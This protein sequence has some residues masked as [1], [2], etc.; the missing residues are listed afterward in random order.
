[1]S[2][3]IAL[4]G[5]F[6][7]ECWVNVPVLNAQQEYLIETYGIGGP[8]GYVLRLNW[9]NIMV[10]AMGA[11]QPSAVSTS[12]ITANAWHHVAATFND[13]SNEV[14]F[15]IDGVFDNSA[16][17][18]VDNITSTTELHIGARGDDSD[19]ND[20]LYMDEVRIW[21]IV[22]SDAEIAAGMNSCMMG[23]EQGLV[24]YYDFE[25]LGTGNTVTDKTSNGN[26][27]TIVSNV[28]PRAAGVFACC[29]VN[30]QI[31]ANGSVL[32]A[33]P[34][35]GTYQW[36]NCSDNTPIN[37]A[38]SQSF[39]AT[40]NGDYACV[41][42]NGSCVDTTSCITVSGLGI[43]EASLFSFSVYPNPAQHTLTIDVGEAIQAVEILSPNGTKVQRESEKQFS[44]AQ[45]AS[46]VYLLKITTESGSALTRFVKE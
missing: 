3:S 11:S 25:D 15:Y 45:L 9:G 14:R 36:I 34:N 13:M 17:L 31:T 38:T 46:G 40:A 30:N 27:G 4:D 7:L 2:P 12:T 37:G 29:F 33:G 42:D 18:N 41:I 1:M 23:N 43:S 26:T 20:L 10:Y 28:D 8:G 19:V 22:R 5:D 35:P 24:L 21:N 6:T 44:V 39:T 16:S 32:T